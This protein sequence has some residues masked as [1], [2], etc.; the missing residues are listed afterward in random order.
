MPEIIVPISSQSPISLRLVRPLQSGPDQLSAIRRPTTSGSATTYFRKISLEKRHGYT[1]GSPTNKASSS[2]IF[3]DFHT[4]LMRGASESRPWDDLNCDGACN[5]FDSLMAAMD[6]QIIVTRFP[7]RMLPHLQE[8]LGGILK[9]LKTAPPKHESL[10]GRFRKLL[11]RDF[12]FQTQHLPTVDSQRHPPSKS[13]LYIDPQ[14]DCLLSARYKVWF[15]RLVLGATSPRKIE[16]LHSDTHTVE[17]ARVGFG[18]RMHPGESL[19]AHIGK[20]ARHPQAPGSSTKGLSGKFLDFGL[21][22]PIFSNVLELKNP[23]S[24]KA[25]PW[26][27]FA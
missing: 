23:K 20:V 15:T 18:S 24:D 4:A 6:R 10:T 26:M 22:N 1:I 8:N 2:H 5:T 12:R 9:C 11:H 17:R 27:K 16:A 14:N 25:L 19:L 21:K 13:R 3:F 7:Q